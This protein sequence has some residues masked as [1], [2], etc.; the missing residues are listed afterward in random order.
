MLRQVFC[1]RCFVVTNRKHT[2]TPKVSFSKRH[3]VTHQ[4]WNSVVVSNKK[5]DVCEAETRQL[6]HCLEDWAATTWNAQH[7]QT[8]TFPKR[9]A[10]PKSGR[11]GLVRQTITFLC[12][13]WDKQAHQATTCEHMATPGKMHACM[14]I[15]V[16]LLVFDFVSTVVAICPPQDRQL[17][18]T[19]EGKQGIF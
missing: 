14:F 8:V 17:A 19:I 11:L 16:C 9:Y 12:E 13:S 1:W 2:S 5:S 18:F 10:R 15:G 4:I 7:P 3:P 6:Q